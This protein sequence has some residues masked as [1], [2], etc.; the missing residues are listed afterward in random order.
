MALTGRRPAERKTPYP[1]LL[2]DGQ[3]ETRQAPGTSFDPSP[4][5]S[6]T[7]RTAANSTSKMFLGTVRAHYADPEFGQRMPRNKPMRKPCALSEKAEETGALELD[8]SG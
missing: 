3:L 5:S 2:F 4:P 1:A 7:P 8:L 6:A